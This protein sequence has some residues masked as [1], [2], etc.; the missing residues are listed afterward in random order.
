MDVLYD[1]KI[2]NHKN[3]PVKLLANGEIKKKLTIDLP[4]ISKTA[5]EMVEKAG[6][7]IIVS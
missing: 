2:I 4:S 6:G 5:K 7:K 1:K 3:N